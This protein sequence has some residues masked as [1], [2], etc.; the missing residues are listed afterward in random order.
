M[1]P[2]H[3]ASLAY[4]TAITIPS[5][6]ALSITKNGNQQ[7]TSQWKTTN[8]IRRKGRN[9]TFLYY[10]YTKHTS[11]PISARIPNLFSNTLYIPTVRRTIILL[12][13]T[14]G[15]KQIYIKRKSPLT[16]APTIIYGDNTKLINTPL[17]SDQWRSWG[18][19]YWKFYLSNIRGQ[20]RTY[21]CWND[22]TH[23]GSYHA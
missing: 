13:P 18:A 6:N 14:E 8:Q 23:T 21:Y 10:Y 11:C 15:T 3:I 1:E 17:K 7:P 4:F 2:I 19:N 22:L 16:N 12:P 9:S 20:N 5:F